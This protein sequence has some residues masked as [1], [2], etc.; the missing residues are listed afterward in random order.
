MGVKNMF[1]SVKRAQFYTM[2]VVIIAIALIST[3]IIILG[4]RNNIKDVK[5]SEDIY[6]IFSNIKRETLERVELILANLTQADKS[7][8]LTGYLEITQYYLDEWI[9]CLRNEYENRGFKIDLSYNSDQISYTRYWT[10]NITA[11]ILRAIIS[12]QIEDEDAS[13]KQIVNA[14]HIFRLYIGKI[15]RVDGKLLV[16]VNFTK[17]VGYSNELSIDYATIYINDTLAN[18]V[19]GGVYRA[20][21]AFTGSGTITI[22]VAATAPSGV[23]VEAL[24]TYSLE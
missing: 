23:F 22:Y 19:G 18:Y 13:I 14:T 20:E 17:I 10:G 15:E 11:S 21:L 4:A 8:T 1:V 7:G 2:A 3:S 9:E 5:V 6:F 16:E 12:V 24:E